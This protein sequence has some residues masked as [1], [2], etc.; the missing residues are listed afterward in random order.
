M[1]YCSTCGRPKHKG[2]CDMATLENGITVHADRIGKDGTVDGVRV[3]NLW[4]KKDL[5]ARR[6]CEK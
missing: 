6:E 1:K 5:I 3:K 2:M 4:I